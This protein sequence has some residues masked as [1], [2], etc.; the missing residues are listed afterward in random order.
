MDGALAAK[1]ARERNF[2]VLFTLAMLAGTVA[3]LSTQLPWGPED[4][5]IADLP[6]GYGSLLIYVP[7][8]VFSAWALFVGRFQPSGIDGA[9]VWRSG[10][11]ATVIL[12]LELIS[13]LWIVQ[14]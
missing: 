10:P 3:L 14:R 4:L 7:A 5:S 12:A 9:E 11:G 1:N 8:V 2:W 13:I 6:Q